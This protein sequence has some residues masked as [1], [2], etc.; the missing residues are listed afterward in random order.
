MWKNYFSFIK[1]KPGK[2]ITTLFGELDFSRDDIPL[3]KIQQ[4]YENDFPYLKITPLGE[5][6]IYGIKT[7]P[8][9][10]QNTAKTA[11][12]QSKRKKKLAV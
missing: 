2:V 12:K 5:E 4:L 6:T 1:L 7:D 3:S 11:E 10:E 8:K 9:P